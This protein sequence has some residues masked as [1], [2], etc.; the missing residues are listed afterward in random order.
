FGKFFGVVAGTGIPF[1]RR[2]PSVVGYVS[3][4]QV[5]DGG[6]EIIQIHDSWSVDAGGIDSRGVDSGRVDARRVGSHIHRRV[7]RP[8]RGDARRIGWYRD[9]SWRLD[10]WS[11][12]RRVHNTRGIDP[13]RV[14][15]RGVDSR[16][17]HP[18]GLAPR[19]IDAR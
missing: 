13:G 4:L 10:A 15:G 11:V 17:I 16:R 5:G 18:R 2:P 3:I 7:H 8:A 19:G 12:V 14:D 1:V 9:D 6:R